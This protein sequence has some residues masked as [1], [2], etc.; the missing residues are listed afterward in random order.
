MTL[1]APTAM[2]VHPAEAAFWIVL[3]PIVGRLRACRGRS[4]GLD[5]GPSAARTELAGSLEHG[6]GALDRF[7]ADHVA[8]ANGNRLANVHGAGLHQQRPAKAMSACALEVGW[9]RVSTPTLA[10]CSLR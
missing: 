4:G 3:I 2:H 9:V 5:E 10:M 6:I 1:P 8:L 7:N